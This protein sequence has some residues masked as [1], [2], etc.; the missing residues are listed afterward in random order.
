MKK[1]TPHGDE[2]GGVTIACFQKAVIISNKSLYWRAVLFSFL[3]N[4]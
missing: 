4:I 3:T 2:K 1:V